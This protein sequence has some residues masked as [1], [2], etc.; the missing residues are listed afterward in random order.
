MSTALPGLLH[1]FDGGCSE[2]NDYVG[3]TAEEA[4][5]Q[6]DCP[7]PAPN[8]CP[9]KPANQ[10]MLDSIHSYMDYSPDAC[11]NQF[12]AGQIVQ[13]GAMWVSRPGR[14]VSSCV[15][16]IDF[17]PTSSETVHLLWEPINPDLFETLHRACFRT[18]TEPAAKPF[19]ARRRPDPHNLHPVHLP[20]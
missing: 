7:N 14:H 16:F 1:P 5:P 19:R 6:Y 3:D 18:N 2:P 11:M 15:H 8:S 4:G 10:P 9:N 17:W 20:N 13:M 12:T